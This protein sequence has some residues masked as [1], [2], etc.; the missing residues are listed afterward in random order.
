[1][2]NAVTPRQIAA[3]N[4]MADIM[5]NI[6]GS[7]ALQAGARWVSQAPA[8]VVSRDGPMIRKVCA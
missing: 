2:I 7:F 3:A 4:V 6:G 5:V 8:P 1:M